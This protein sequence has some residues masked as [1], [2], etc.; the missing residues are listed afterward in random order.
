MPDR[1]WGTPKPS[2]TTL[3]ELEIQTP[4]CLHEYFQYN[5]LDFA[6]L[7]SVCVRVRVCMHI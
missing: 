4:F 1:E 5:I 6:E 2:C 7:Q 3:S